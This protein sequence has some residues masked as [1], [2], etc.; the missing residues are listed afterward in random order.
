M[1]TFDVMTSSNSEHNDNIAFFIISLV[2]IIAGMLLV[3]N[4]IPLETPLDIK[5]GWAL[6]LAGALLLIGSIIRL[7]GS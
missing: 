3:L 6:I 5:I 1:L 2:L 4:R 7:L